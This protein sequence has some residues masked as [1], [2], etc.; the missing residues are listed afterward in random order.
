MLPRSGATVSLTDQERDRECLRR[1]Q[2][3]ESNALA[4]LYDRYT[5]LLYPVVLRILRSAADAEDALQDAWVQVWKR[6]A[7]YDP[8]RGT[9]AAWLVTVARTRAID[10]YRS[11]ASRGRAE[12]SVDPEPAGAPPDPTSNAARAQLRDR[13]SGAL[14]QLSPEQRRVLEIAYFQ[15]LSQSEIAERLEA[16]LG[17]VK[18]WTRQGLTRLR[19]LLPREDWV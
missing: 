13:V 16:P 18:S 3:G 4:E 12:S 19:E 9:V 15:G 11:A 5:P 2:A 14:A 7:S 1:V 6:A 17:T 10:R 8:R